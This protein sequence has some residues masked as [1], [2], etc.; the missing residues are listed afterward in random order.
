M[1]S[2]CEKPCHECPFRANALRGYLGGFSARETYGAAV[3][4]DDFDCHLTRAEGA[5]RRHC[6]GR[7]MFA[8]KMC[9]SFRRRDL[10]QARQALKQQA[11][12]VEIL[13]RN[14]I[15]YHEN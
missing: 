13:G 5:E 10:E 12:D 11:P 7:L 14:F 1:K 4:E 3:S 15:E 9:K 8:T 6:A 2:A